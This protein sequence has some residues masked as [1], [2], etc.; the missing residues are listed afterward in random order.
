MSTVTCRVCSAD[1]DIDECDWIAPDLCC[2]CANE[3]V[4][5]VFDRRG[6]LEVIPGLEV[7]K[8]MLLLIRGDRWLVEP[9]VQAQARHGYEPGVLLV[10]GIPEAENDV[11]AMDAAIA[12]RD[13]IQNGF[14]I[15]GAR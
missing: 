11:E 5:I 1:C 13:R 6:V 8:G 10:P 14:W 15:W 9:V 4:S 7:P 3:P 12:F 2:A